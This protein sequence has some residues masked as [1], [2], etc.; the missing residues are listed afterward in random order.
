MS[1]YFEKNLK[2]TYFPKDI[3][4]YQYSIIQKTAHNNTF[5][6]KIKKY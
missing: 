1:F 2:K 6:W 3:T 4:K 5:L